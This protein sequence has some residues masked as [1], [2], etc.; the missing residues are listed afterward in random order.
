[1]RFSKTYK[2]FANRLV[3]LIVVVVVVVVFA[4]Y[5]LDCAKEQTV[6]LE[7]ERLPRWENLATTLNINETSKPGAT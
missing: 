1:M 2:W 4:E 3:V 7:V 5:R 6:C